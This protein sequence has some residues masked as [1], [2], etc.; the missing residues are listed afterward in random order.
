MKALKSHNK[1]VH[2]EAEKVLHE[3]R[4]KEAEKIAAMTPEEK[5]QYVAEQEEKSRKLKELL[6][7]P[8][9]T[10]LMSDGGYTDQI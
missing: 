9:L 4:R 3:E 7:I 8:G 2:R 1:A 6:T 5:A 10:K